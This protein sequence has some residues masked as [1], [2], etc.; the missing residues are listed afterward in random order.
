MLD[1]VVHKL[2]AKRKGPENPTAA[3]IGGKVTGAEMGGLLAFM[4]SKILG[5]YDLAPGGTPRLLL[6]APNIVATERK[7]EVNPR[8]FRR[9]VAMHEETHRVQFT[10]VPWLREHLITRSQQT[11]RRPGADARRDGPAPRA[12]GPQPLR[13]VHLG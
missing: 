11:G 3:A 4:S 9:W 10:A 13:G 2:T 5:Q 7:L 6:V 12:A 8:D 1:P